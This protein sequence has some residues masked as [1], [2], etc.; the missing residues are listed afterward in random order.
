M[1]L[2]VLACQP[3]KTAEVCQFSGSSSQIENFQRSLRVEICRVDFLS[4]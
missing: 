4:L 3:M 1:E 2:L